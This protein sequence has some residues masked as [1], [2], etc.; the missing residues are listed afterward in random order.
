MSPQPPIY[1]LISYSGESPNIIFLNAQLERFVELQNI[2]ILSNVDNCE[3]NPRSRSFDSE[4]LIHRF[5]DC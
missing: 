4:A 1:I 3:Q 2:R 5:I